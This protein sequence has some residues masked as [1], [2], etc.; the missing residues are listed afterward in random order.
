MDEIKELQEK[1]AEIKK[2]LAV[3]ESTIRKVEQKIERIESNTSWTVRL[4]I[5]AIIMAVIRIILKGG[6]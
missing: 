3:A 1:I 4:I 6:I 5:G 2:R